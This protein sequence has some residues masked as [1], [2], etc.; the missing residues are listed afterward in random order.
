LHKDSQ[1]Q[2]NYKG[3]QNNSLILKR[4]FRKH[5]TEMVTANNQLSNLCR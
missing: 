1:N 3:T 4:F 2:Q 5:E